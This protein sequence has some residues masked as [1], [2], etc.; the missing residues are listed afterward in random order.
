MK[1]MDNE[2]QTIGARIKKARE[3]SGMSQSD[4]AKVLGFESATAISLIEND[5]RKITAENLGK[6]A[7]ALHRD[8]RYFLGEEN[9]KTVDVAVALRADKDLSDPDKKAI[10]HFIEMARKKKNDQ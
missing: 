2:A 8:V 1:N 9:A 10:L 3:E 6:A 7:A 5:E 4:L